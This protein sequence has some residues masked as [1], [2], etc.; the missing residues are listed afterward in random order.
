MKAAKSYI[1]SLVHTDDTAEE[2]EEKEKDAEEAASPLASPKGK[3]KAY[4]DDEELVGSGKY[5]NSI[6]TL[7]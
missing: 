3:G 7:Y 2:E 5:I 1:S 6:Y 4:D